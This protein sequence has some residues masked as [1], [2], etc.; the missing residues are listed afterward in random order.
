MRP[1]E[2]V[3]L[4]RSVRDHLADMSFANARLVLLEFGFD[5][6]DEHGWFATD[7]DVLLDTMLGGGPDAALRPWPTTSSRPT[8]LKRQGATTRLKNRG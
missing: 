6:I 1:H 8:R 3:N 2:R 5:Q 7:R 4:I